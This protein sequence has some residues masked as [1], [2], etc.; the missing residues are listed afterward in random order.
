MTLTAATRSAS[1]NQRDLAAAEAHE[2]ILAATARCLISRGLAGARMA[3]IAS[4][5]GVSTAL[6]HYHFKTKAKLFAAMLT[7]TEAKS[8][9]LTEQ[10]LAA[11]GPTAS[12]R[13]AGFVDRL[14]PTTDLLRQE[15]IVWQELEAM[16][17][18]DAELAQVEIDLYAGY[19]DTV[20]GLIRQGRD[21]GEF[22]DGPD[23]PRDLAEAVVAL[24]D[25]VGA[26]VV[27]AGEDLSVEQARVLV[28]TMAGR[29]IGHP[30][31]LPLPGLPR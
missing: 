19:Y 9:T 30:G 20:A 26:R 28:A 14:L 4:A 2:K 31:P 21:S 25:G 27:S 3:A 10:A 16:S 1:P 23:D 24:C 13:L 8:R 5:A 7:W 11:A 17:L 12:A 15:W 22:A 18:R 29:L 6:L